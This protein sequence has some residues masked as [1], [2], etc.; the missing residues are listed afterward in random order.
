MRTLETTKAALWAT[1]GFAAPVLKAQGNDELY[2]FDK[3]SM[4]DGKIQWRS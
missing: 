2:C 4:G 3:D 1:L